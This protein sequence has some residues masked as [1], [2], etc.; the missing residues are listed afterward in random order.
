MIATGLALSVR[1]TVSQPLPVLVLGVRDRRPSLRGD[2]RV[3]GDRGLAFYFTMFNPDVFPISK[4]MI[5]GQL[6]REETEHEHLAEL[7]AIECDEAA[8]HVRPGA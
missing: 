1:G 2:A 4:V 7:C 6:T 3:A 5:T 8:R